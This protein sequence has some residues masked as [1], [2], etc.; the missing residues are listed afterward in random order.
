MGCIQTKK[1]I[2]IESSPF[3]D[4]KNGSNNVV[5]HN[6]KKDNNSN[7]ISDINKS[8][9]NQEDKDKEKND[10][11]IHS[12]SQNFKVK[13][14]IN[15][16]QSKSMNSK[17][18]SSFYNHSVSNSE[19]DSEIFKLT[20]NNNDL[21]NKD[22]KFEDKYEIINEENLESYFQTFKIKLIDDQSSKEVYRSMFKIQKEIFGEFANDKKISEEVS[23]LSKLDSRYIIKVYECFISNKKYYLITDYC[24][25]GSLSLKL[26]NKNIYNENQIRYLVL[27]IFKAIKYLNMNNYLH[28]EIS[29]E[30]ILIDYITKDVH[31]DELYNIKL[32]DFFCPSKNN[33]IYNNKSPYFCYMAPEVIEQKYSPTCDIWSIGIILFQMFFGDLPYKDEDDFQEYIKNIKTIYNSSNSISIEFKDLLDKMLIQNPLNRITINECLSHPWVH[34]Q[35]TEIIT[36]EEEEINNQQE[37]TRT[38]TNISQKDKKRKKSYKSK[39]TKMESKKMQYY[40]EHNSYKTKLIEVPL[41]RNSSSISDSNSYNYENNFKTP[42][43]NKNE[44]KDTKDNMNNLNDDKENKFKIDKIKIDRMKINSNNNLNTNIDKM[45]NKLFNNS[46]NVHFNSELIPKNITSRKRKTLKRLSTISAINT[47]ENK[48]QIKFHPLIDKTINYIKFFININFKKNREIE[49]LIKIFHELDNKKN[50]YLLYD[51][52]YFACIS[53]RDNK[54]ISIESFNNLN[55]KNF[56]NDEKYNLNDFIDILIDEKTKYINSNFKNVFESIKQPNIDEIIKIYKD[57]EPIGEYK[58]YVVYIKDYVKLIQ[59]NEAKKNYFYNEF[60]LLVDNSINN[61]YKKN[62]SSLNID[63]IIYNYNYYNNSREVSPNNSSR[64]NIRKCK[65]KKFFKDKNNKSKNPIKRSNTSLK[66]SKLNN[67][68]LKIKN[69]N[70]IN[71]NENNMDIVINES[72]IYNLEIDQFSPNRFLRLTNK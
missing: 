4:T 14:P 56:N 29:P 71:N 64:E 67:I 5:V 46:N 53:Y 36:E 47:I 49:K 35:N 45:K 13:I 52:V 62:N 42:N 50:N 51:K 72:K 31:G 17:R 68:D 11:M 58:K 60:K 22:L 24:Q 59:E 57:Q 70:E 1:L 25:N 37:L 28:I 30:K 41:H 20:M 27:Q 39:I 2:K 3:D 26:K 21:I 48:N 33:F 44:K 69:N 32:L 10:K 16:N 12:N 40:S 34:K 63:Y 7:D 43:N 6:I 66:K 65:T 15:D 8:S 9:N 55:I 19:E 61:I 23:L 38:K 18:N 54:R